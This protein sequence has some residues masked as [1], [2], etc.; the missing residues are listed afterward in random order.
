MEQRR[1]CEIVMRR[2]EIGTSLNER[3]VH[4][5][6]AL[7]ALEI[8]GIKRG[9]RV[10]KTRV[11]IQIPEAVEVGLR[12]PRAGSR[13]R[14]CSYSFGDE[15]VA[16]SITGFGLTS[17]NCITCLPVTALSVVNRNGSCTPATSR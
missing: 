14:S 2:L 5:D 15:N 12:Q 8:A 6:A 3:W 13:G 7:Q 16:A 11:R 17:A 4:R 9:D 10:I 1:A